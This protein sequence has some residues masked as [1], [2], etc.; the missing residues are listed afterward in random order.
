MYLSNTC[1]V[2]HEYLSQAHV[3]P[4]IHMMHHECT[5]QVE[6]LGTTAGTANETYFCLNL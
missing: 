1:G 5:T 6:G 4:L 3:L 2:L